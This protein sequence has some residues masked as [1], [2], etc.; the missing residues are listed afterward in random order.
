ML[1]PC[2]CYCSFVCFRL[3]ICSFRLLQRLFFSFFVCFSVLCFSLSLFSF[4]FLFLVSV[5]LFSTAFVHVF[6]PS[7]LLSIF[8]YS[9]YF[10]LVLSLS[11]SLSCISALFV[12]PRTFL[13]SSPTLSLYSTCHLPSL[14]PSLLPLHLPISSSFPSIPLPPFLSLFLFLPPFS[15]LATKLLRVSTRW[16]RHMDLFVVAPA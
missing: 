11:L 8:S 1:V 13:H 15:P 14:F 12:Y 6:L 4:L 16:F 3:I 5:F 2:L 9:Y 7:I 10:T